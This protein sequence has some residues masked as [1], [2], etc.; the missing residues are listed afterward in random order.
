MGTGASA[1]NFFQEEVSSMFQAVYNSKA[2][3]QV[4]DLLIRSAFWAVLLLLFLPPNLALGSDGKEFFK[5]GKCDLDAGRYEEAVEKLVAAAKEF[6]LLE[7]YT[8]LY[9]SAAYHEL[10]DHKKSL[11]A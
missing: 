6:P 1:D 2:M 10:G 8:L 5:G 7:D 9:L 11:D 4:I 3:S